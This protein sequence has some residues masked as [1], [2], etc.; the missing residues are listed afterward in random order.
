M[1]G[2]SGIVSVGP[3]QFGHGMRRLEELCAGP[4]R[5]P[6]A[7]GSFESADVVA[8]ARCAVGVDMWCDAPSEHLLASLL[9]V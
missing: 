2:E 3:P 9:F 6:V 5:G 8:A 1:V 7:E 4:M